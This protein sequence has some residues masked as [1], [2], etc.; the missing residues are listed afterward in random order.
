MVVAIMKSSWTAQLEELVTDF[1]E[2]YNDLL[3]IVISLERIVDG[4][5]PRG[6]TLAWGHHPW[7]RCTYLRQ[8][9]LTLQA[10][11]EDIIEFGIDLKPIA[12]LHASIFLLE[13]HFS[14]RRHVKKRPYQVYVS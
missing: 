8:C 5:T 6:F 3:T 4:G 9:G 2:H 14:H 13:F 1:K 7:Q 10:G 11:W 12:H